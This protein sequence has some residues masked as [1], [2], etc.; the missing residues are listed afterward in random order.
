[1][2]DFQWKALTPVM[3]DMDGWGTLP[4]LPYAGGDPHTG[5]CRM[6]LKL[7]STLMPYLYTTAASAAGLDTGNGDACLPMVRSVLLEDESARGDAE[8]YEFL[9]GDALLVA[10]VYRSVRPDAAGNDRSPRR[11]LPA[12]QR[13]GRLDRLVH[14]SAPRRRADA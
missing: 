12:R 5:I 14:R 8:K 3:L 4:K 13:E 11:H 7:K 2:R 9:L 10:P 6:Y 1:M